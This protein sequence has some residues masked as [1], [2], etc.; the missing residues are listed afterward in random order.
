VPKG[1][2]VRNRLS[3]PGTLKVKERGERRRWGEGGS[4]VILPCAGGEGRRDQTCMWGTVNY[5]ATKRG[6][7]QEAKSEGSVQRLRRKGKRRMKCKWDPNIQGE[8]G[9]FNWR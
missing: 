7:S 1:D 8:E 2:G 6:D 3:G 9:T 4:K 5:F